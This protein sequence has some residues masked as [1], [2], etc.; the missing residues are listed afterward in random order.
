MQPSTRV[1]R[2]IRHG[3]QDDFRTKTDEIKCVATGFNQSARDWLAGK[4]PTYDNYK[5]LK[6]CPVTQLLVS[7][8]QHLI[9]C[10]PEAAVEVVR[11]PWTRDNRLGVFFRASGFLRR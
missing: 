9:V 2:V 11:E 3:F 1:S 7:I 4:R 8:L 6:H 5:P 10:L